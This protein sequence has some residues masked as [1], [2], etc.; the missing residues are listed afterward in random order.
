MRL[1]GNNS[2]VHVWQITFYSVAT[3][4]SYS[5]YHFSK[6]VQRLV[7]CGNIQTISLTPDKN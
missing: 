2:S 5:G 7:K 1:E 6:L 4:W 3:G